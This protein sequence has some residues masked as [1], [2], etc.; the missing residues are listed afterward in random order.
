VSVTFTQCAAQRLD[1]THVVATR[2]ACP[3]EVNESLR[4]RSGLGEVPGPRLGTAPPPLRKA[5][6]P[7][8]TVRGMP[9]WQLLLRYDNRDEIDAELAEDEAWN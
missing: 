8:K 6:R 7:G 9:T 3:S 5:A 2:A 4:T 1:R